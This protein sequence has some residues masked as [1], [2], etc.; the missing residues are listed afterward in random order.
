MIE[1]N[2]KNELD[3]IEI[4]LNKKKIDFEEILK[5][6]NLSEN[7]DISE[8]VDN[9]LTKNQKKTLNILK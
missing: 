1:L 3:K 8:L 6:T 4:I 2:L 9:S 7:Y 5:L